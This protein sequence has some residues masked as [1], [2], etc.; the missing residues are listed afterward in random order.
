MLSLAGM[1]LSTGIW[2]YNTPC[3]HSSTMGNSNPLARLCNPKL[4]RQ[5]TILV[6]DFEEAELENYRVTYTILNNLKLATAEYSD[7]RVK[8]L[9]RTI[10]NLAG[11]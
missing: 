1:A 2:T 3:T 11:T 10:T 5:I 8:A 4:A 6:A 7:V 9:G